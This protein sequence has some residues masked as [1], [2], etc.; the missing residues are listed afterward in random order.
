[1]PLKVRRL[2]FTSFI[3]TISVVS[4]SAQQ[5]SPTSPTSN[6]TTNQT[7]TSSPGSQ[8][9]TTTAAPTTSTTPTVATIPF[10]TSKDKMARI[11]ALIASR[12]LSTA[13]VELEKI[14]RETGDETLQNVSRVMLVELYLEQ[15]NYERA[16]D[17]LEDTFKREK[18][19]RATSD[20]VYLMVAGQV[21]KSAYAQAERYK[22]LGFNIT[23]ANLPKEATS[24]LDKWR[25]M[26]EM[27][28]EQSKQMSLDEKKA[29]AAFVVLEEAATARGT[30]ARDVYE[31]AQWRRTMDDTRD[32]IAQ[33]QTKVAE[34]DGNLNLIPTPNAAINIQ[35]APIEPVAADKE[36]VQS[37]P[38]NTASTNNPSMSLPA[39]TVD[40]NAGTNNQ[41]S[42]RSRTVE[43]KTTLT[44]N[45]GNVDSAQNVEAKSKETPKETVK[46]EIT[47]I[48]SMVELATRKVNPNYPPVAKA[49]RIGGIVKVEI[50]VDEVGKVTDVKTTNGPEM[51]K[52]AAV[53]AVKRWQ[54]R[55]TLRD[56]QPVRVTGFVN[57]N[58]AL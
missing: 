10:S 34:V 57:F 54:F 43:E 52:R 16:K 20:N 21:I 8:N 33:T 40:T 50:V 37:S 44:I 49:A 38:T 1:M 2:L 28:I 12:N 58:F 27:V 56:G 51:L 35:T 39:T 3:V 9:P 41:T 4:V 25:A 17:L 48:G 18:S 45:N 14:K 55:P 6:E 42:A 22:R 11:R 5:T 13:V 19:R 32:A 15:P 36:K 46:D 7:A 47:Q 53:D 30:L 24:D 31:T 29:S 23:D 26:L